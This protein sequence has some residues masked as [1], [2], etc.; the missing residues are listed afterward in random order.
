MSKRIEGINA[1]LNAMGLEIEARKGFRTKEGK[2]RK[3]FAVYSTSGEHYMGSDGES[4]FRNFFG[5]SF[6]LDSVKELTIDRVNAEMVA[7]CGK[8]LEQIAA[9]VAPKAAAEEAR[10][11][12]A[13]RQI[14]A[15]REAE[16][17]V[18]DD[19]MQPASEADLHRRVTQLMGRVFADDQTKLEWFRKDLVQKRT[20]VDDRYRTDFLR[21][22]RDE[23]VQKM[24]SELLGRK[25]PEVFFRQEYSSLMRVFKEAQA[26]GIDGGSIGGVHDALRYLVLG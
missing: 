7:G 11:A 2:S 1:Q 21:L 22:I 20:L 12:E 15:Q 16:Q 9:E 24:A 6:C 17:T 5:L 18:L 4:N 19:A 23:R 8:N 14:A 13:R 3:R 26:R 25:A 10:I